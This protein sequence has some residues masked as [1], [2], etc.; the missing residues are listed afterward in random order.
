MS[1]PVINNIWSN[2][3]GCRDL[4]TVLKRYRRHIGGLK[5][6]DFPSDPEH[7]QAL[8]DPAKA[9]ALDAKEKH[10]KNQQLASKVGRA[11][12]SILGKFHI[13]L[14]AYGDLVALIQGLDPH[15]KLAC[16]ALSL[17]ILVIPSI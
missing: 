1:T 16:Q 9:Q 15:V 6:E 3:K 7:V 11:T 12:Q 17:M 2:R 5:V 14:K 13:Y 10:H 8:I 4:Y